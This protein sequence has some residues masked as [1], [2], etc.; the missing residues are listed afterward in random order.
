MFLEVLSYYSIQPILFIIMI[1]KKIISPFL[2]NAC[3]YYP[4]CSQYAHGALLKHGLV[5]GLFL[6]VKR[7]LRCNPLF[8]GG[9]DPVP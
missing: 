2:P 9:Y 5:Y 4:T 6:S 1:Y 7:L 8:P 3:R